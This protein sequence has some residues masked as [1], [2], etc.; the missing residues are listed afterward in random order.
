MFKN[1]LTKVAGLALLLLTARPVLAQEV[2]DTDPNTLAPS[3]DPK[4][5]ANGLAQT[6]PMGW[7][8]WN[9]FA[10]NVNE[11]TIRATADAIASNGMKQA[12]YQY[13]VI[14]DCWHGPRDV[15]GFI[16]EDKT[17]FPSGLKALGDYVHAKGLKFGIY[18]DAGTKTCG[19][20]PGSQ[21]HEYQDAV[22]YAR[23][24]VD[25]LKYDWCSTGVRNAE[26]AYA[27]MSDAL[28]A[29]GRPILFSMCEWGNSKPWLWASK[30]GNMWRTTGDIT[31]KWKGKYNYSW[32]V[33][34][35]VDM[36]EP[37]WPYAGP[38]HW[39]DPD[40]LEVGNGG[41]S[42]VEYRAH[43]SLWAMMA[44]PLIAGNDVAAMSSAT[45]DILLN[46]DVIAVDQDALGVQGHRVVRNGDL[47]VWAKPMADGGRAV[48]LWN[49]GEAPARI[50]ADW[51]ALSL[52][53]K[54]RMQVRDLWAHKDLGRRA[55][56]YEAEV[57]PHGVV[58]VRL[59]P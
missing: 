49:R 11:Q 50:A 54:V 48:L 22:Q 55:G 57:A 35:I 41:L 27:L 46:R 52:P 43:F 30:I 53:R 14:D 17:R 37:L 15:N 25:Y 23:W 6:P 51:A 4:R 24:G 19:G 34:S 58:M 7:N 32:G 10:C 42:D 31:D 20:R 8:S 26:E 3:K 1:T 44:S 56:S 29:S 45:R 28:R 16:T 2:L 47:E 36:N 40:M 18:S 13:V 39:N 38:G 12:G 5:T 33:S 21:G 59:T 9:K